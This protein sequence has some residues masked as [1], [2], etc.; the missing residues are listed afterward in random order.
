MDN[1]CQ[2]DNSIQVENAL[3]TALKIV[4]L[5]YIFCP[6]F[7]KIH[8]PKKDVIRLNLNKRLRG[9]LLGGVY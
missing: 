6:C 2:C 8:L 3:K 9:E 4:L 5:V 1:F 7:M